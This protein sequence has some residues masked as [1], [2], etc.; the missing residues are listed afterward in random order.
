[1]EQKLFACP[2][3][4]ASPARHRKCFRLRLSTT[5]H[6]KQ[7]LNRKHAPI[8]C[9]H[10]LATFP[11][12]SDCDEHLTRDEPCQRAP[13]ERLL[14]GLSGE[15]QARLSQRS[16]GDGEEAW[17]AIWEICF[18]RRARPRSPYYYQ[19][20]ELSEDCVVYQEDLIRQGPALLVDEM[21]RDGT[22]LLALSSPG[23]DQVEILQRVFELVIRRFNGS[24]RPPGREVGDQD[25]PAS[26]VIVPIDVDG[27]LVNTVTV[28]VEDFD[29]SVSVAQTSPSTVFQDLARSIQQNGF[30]PMEP[31][32]WMWQSPTMV[33]G[34]NLEDHSGQ[35]FDAK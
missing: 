30:S 13:E 29:P 12:F 10:C 11:E 6:V 26:G 4:K 21:Q 2:F 33:D 14:D 15:Q 17:F 35:A 7:H 5:S 9:P 24:W 31:L 16:K 34:I 32:P 28:P 20:G 22:L 25:Q 18:P 1:M 23:A 8:Y 27:S 19:D 3:W